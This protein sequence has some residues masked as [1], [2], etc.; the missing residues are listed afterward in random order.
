[1]LSKLSKSRSK[2]E[3]LLSKSE[4]NDDKS[5]HDCIANISKQLVD[6]EK[7][8]ISYQDKVRRILAETELIA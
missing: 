3:L 4:V 2:R 6:F 7:H 1:M 8:L 5:V